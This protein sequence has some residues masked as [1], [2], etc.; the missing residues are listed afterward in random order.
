MATMHEFQQAQNE[1][2]LA[3]P[4]AAA[5]EGMDK[6]LINLMLHTLRHDRAEVFDLCRDY[7]DGRHTDPYAPRDAT[8]QIRDLQRRSIT[9]LVPLLVNLPAQVS[10][11]DGYRRGVDEPEDG[12]PS[13]KVARSTPE[14]K[15]WQKNRMDA[16]QSTIYRAALTYG[17]A[18]AHVNNL[19]PDNVK[20]EILSTRNT[21][22]FFDDPVNDI[23]PSRALTIKSHPRSAD[24]PGLAV[25]WDAE[26]RTEINYNFDGSFTQRGEPI[27]HGLGSCPVV[28]YTC[29]ID[30]EGTTCGVITPIIPLQ[31][32]VN[33]ATFST[34]VTSD[35]GAFKVRTAAGLVPNVK[36]DANSEPV[37]DT[38]GNPQYEP[39][40][41]SQ[42]RML[43][44]DDPETKFGQLDET[45]MDGYLK[46][47]DQA[48]KNLASA[49]QF[50]LHA[51]LGNVS[52]LSAEALAALEAQFIRLKD[53]LHTSWGESHEELFR[54]LALAVGDA[55]GAESFG[56][57]VRWR[58]M[59]QK[60]FSATLDGLG[61]MVETLQ[62]PKQGAWSMVP[63]VTD[64]DL[65]DW[66]QLKEAE[67]TEAMF[68]DDDT[69]D[70][71]RAAAGRERRSER[72]GSAPRMP[73]D[74][75]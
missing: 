32:R 36:L 17:H 37:V 60:S 57:E 43:L 65:A 13:R 11:V 22:A 70:D 45:P 35:F 3:T 73:Q 10:F 69:R 28:R 51:L 49:A 53:S 58:D 39:I 14:Y 50:P 48:I 42:A 8:E 18:F 27:P 24:I 38:D 34:N 75:E 6:G 12:E 55:E 64:G 74:A 68:Q 67:A 26:S 47:E 9:N 29:Y 1:G 40:V 19:D 21:V 62:V 16:R 7:F 2:P 63:G 71:P 66:K 44:S 61:K 72:R 20:I 31:D 46:G 56:G 30:D 52:N 4:P 59:S 41:V 15:L 25:F 33:Q 5:G 54:L 23:R